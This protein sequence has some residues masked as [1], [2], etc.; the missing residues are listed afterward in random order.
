MMKLSDKKLTEYY[1][2]VQRL[3]GNHESADKR[4]RIYKITKWHF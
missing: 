3:K 1:K 2:N 4:N